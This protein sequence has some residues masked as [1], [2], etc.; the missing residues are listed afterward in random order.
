MVE[1]LSSKCKTKFKLQHY[2]TNKKQTGRYDFMAW[3]VPDQWIR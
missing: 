1:H 3:P 2:K